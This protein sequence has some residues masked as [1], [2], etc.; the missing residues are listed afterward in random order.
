MSRILVQYA[1]VESL[2]DYEV[3]GVGV[4]VGEVATAIVTVPPLLAFSRMVCGMSGAVLRM[5]EIVVMVR[6]KADSLVKKKNAGLCKKF[7]CSQ[8]LFFLNSKLRLN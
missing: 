2:T 7:D 5:P 6:T 3:C 4:S 1:S 8:P